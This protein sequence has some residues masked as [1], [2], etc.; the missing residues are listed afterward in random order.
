MLYVF[1]P[2]AFPVL[3]REKMWAVLEAGRPPDPVA[4]RDMP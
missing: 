2:R 1:T 4:T 3:A